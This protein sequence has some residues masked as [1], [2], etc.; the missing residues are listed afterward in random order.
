M[1]CGSPQQ[2]LAVLDASLEVG[3]RI[4]PVV[5]GAHPWQLPHRVLA[6]LAGGAEELD[7]GVE[8]DVDHG[9]PIAADELV[10]RTLLLCLEPFQ[11]VD[12]PLAHVLVGLRDEDGADGR[13]RAVRE[14]VLERGVRGVVLAGG[15][16]AEAVEGRVHKVLLHS[17]LPHARQPALLRV[18]PDQGRRGLHLLQVLADGHGLRDH[19]AVVELDVRHLPCR[20]LRLSLALPVGQAGKVQDLLHLCQ[21]YALLPREDVHP[22]W[23][24]HLREGVVGLQLPDALLAPSEAAGEAAHAARRGEQSRRRAD[25]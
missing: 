7:G 20:V 14:E 22:E 16:E 1:P 21:V 24:R 17:A 5:Q 25:R 12:A 6:R 13:V 2:P 8:L 18:R 9:E 19:R 10:A 23:V 11:L 4:E 15:R 3:P